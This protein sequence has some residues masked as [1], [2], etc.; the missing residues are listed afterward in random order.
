MNK[1]RKKAIVF[2]LGLAAA[3]L[4]ATSVQAQGVLGNLLDNYYEEL[5]QKNS[6]KGGMLDRSTGSSSISTEDFGASPSGSIVVE[7]FVSSLGSGIL[8]LMAAGAG[9][10]TLKSKKQNETNKKNEENIR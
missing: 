1:I 5:D 8:M 10:A 7:D 4:S 9:Y 3:M 2:S 6:D